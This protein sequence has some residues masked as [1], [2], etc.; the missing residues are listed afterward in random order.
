M[1]K[2]AEQEKK[3]EELKQETAEE[4]KRD[5]Y[6]ETNQRELEKAFDQREL[7]KAFAK[8]YEG[9][10]DEMIDSYDEFISNSSL[11]ELKTYVEIE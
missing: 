3:R 11:D 10:D 2:M 9:T 5:D 4:Q 1:K 6:A 7:E 8:T